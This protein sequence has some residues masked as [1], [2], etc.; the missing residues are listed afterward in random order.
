MNKDFFEEAEEDGMKGVKWK[1]DVHLK[2]HSITEIKN[3]HWLYL[4]MKKAQIYS[5]KKP[6]KYSLGSLQKHVRIIL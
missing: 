4:N 6:Q 2:N 5:L 3:H 1:P